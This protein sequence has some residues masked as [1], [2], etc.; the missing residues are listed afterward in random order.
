MTS[1]AQR[2]GWLINALLLL[3][4]GA[5]AGSAGDSGPWKEVSRSGDLVVYERVHDG[6]S[7]REFK[8][9]GTID[10][11]AA[12]VK[13]VIDDV[14]EYPH[15][16]P[17]MTETRVISTDG[18][19]RVTYAR[20]SPPVVGDRDYT[21]RVHC[22]TRRDAAGN[23]CFCNRWETA[24]ELGPAEKS[25]V[26]RV[27]VSEGSWLL[28]PTQA[29]RKTQATYCI[30]S[31]SGGAIPAFLANAACKTAI[32]KLFEAIGKQAALPKYSL[33]K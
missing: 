14:D 30:Y 27:K 20:L 2:A 29:G 32:P 26:T 5:L 6:S 11:D 17:Y 10:A 7:I 12:V 1:F 13:R 24:N 18:N 33:K 16:M 9:I 22:E 3:G 31:D 28:Q 19:T 23:T 15:F 21:I 8:A 4:C 25:G